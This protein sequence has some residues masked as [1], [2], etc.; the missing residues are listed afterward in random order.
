[1]KGIV[2]TMMEAKMTPDERTTWDAMQEA[3][4]AT[5]RNG[6]RPSIA[7]YVPELEDWVLYRS[8]NKRFFNFNTFGVEPTLLTDEED[9]VAM[10]HLK[11]WL[12]K[13]K[14]SK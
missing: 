12:S 9:R 3:A 4:F 2:P 6:E 11:R 10:D 5:N 1:M 8:D 14:W 13:L 7:L